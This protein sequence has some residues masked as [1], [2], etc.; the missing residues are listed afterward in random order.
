M[1]K[2]NLDSAV[3]LGVSMGGVIVQKFAVEHPDRAAAIILADTFGEL[4]TLGEKLAGLVQVWGFKLFQYLPGELAAKVVA[5]SYEQYGSEVYGYFREVTAEADFDQLVLARK[6]LNRIAIIDELRQV[7]IP[8][9]VLVGDTAS[10]MLEPA[11]KL[12]EALP[13][14]SFQ[15]I[16]GALDP[17]NM[18]GAEQF[19]EAVAAFLSRLSE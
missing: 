19:D 4:A 18:T 15:I 6:A 16:E 9:L 11:R 10:I 17:S 8:A 1:E 5:A 2:L 13:N 14:A 7:N 12:S 3:L